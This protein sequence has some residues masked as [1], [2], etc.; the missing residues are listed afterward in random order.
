MAENKSMDVG[1]S[2]LGFAFVAFAL[3][4]VL[5]GMNIMSFIFGNLGEAQSSSLADGTTTILNET[6]GFLNDSG[7][8]IL[9]ASA[10]NFIGNVIVNHVVNYSDGNGT[11]IDAGDYNVNISTGVLTNATAVDYI[12]ISVNY[13]YTSKTVAK[14][15]AEAVTNNSLVAL[16]TYAEQ[17]DTQFSTLAIAITLVILLA[18]FAFFW[19]FFMGSGGVGTGTAK[20]GPKGNFT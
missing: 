16:E 9:G 10:D 5:F 12:N 7:Y 13:T 18:V 2:V 1:K 15:S 11:I 14:L 19:R 20:A 3:L 4:G 17:S 8:T 6:D